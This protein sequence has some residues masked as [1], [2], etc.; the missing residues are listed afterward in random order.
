MASV[1]KSNGIFHGHIMALSGGQHVLVAVGA[2]FHRAAGSA[3]RHRGHHSEEICLGLLAAKGPAHAPHLHRDRRRGQAKRVGH[4]VLD[5]GGVLGRREHAHLASLARDRQCNLPFKIEMILPADLHSSGETARRSGDRR[6]GVP[7]RERQ[8]F[9]HQIAPGLGIGNGQ[10]SRSRGVGDL[11]QADG[12]ARRVAGLGD[13]SKEWLS[14]EQRHPVG[15]HRIVLFAGRRDIVVGQVRGGQNRHNPGRHAHRLDVERK[16]RMGMFRKPERRVQ[17]ARGFG[18]I[19]DI[20][21]GPRHMA[22]RTVM[23]LRAA[24]G[25]GDALRYGHGAVHAGSSAP[26][27]TGAPP[28][29][30]QTRR[31]N[32]FAAV[33]R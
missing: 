9:G 13:H 28:C 33:M 1:V 23:G 15:Q 20:P 31:S 17:R 14:V 5:L 29:S 6:F 3:R 7:D 25:T 19:V 27:V 11:C 30:N 22:E 24:G 12:P 8:R 4:H 26:S 2:Q 16:G 18:D 21:C 32:P 10:T